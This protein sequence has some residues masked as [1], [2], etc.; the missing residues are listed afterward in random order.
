MPYVY[1]LCVCLMCMPYV[2]ACPITICTKPNS[3]K[4]TRLSYTTLHICIHIIHACTKPDLDEQARVCPHISGT[5]VGLGHQLSP[6][7][8]REACAHIEEHG[9]CRRWQGAC[10]SS[11]RH[12]HPRSSRRATAS[13][14][15]SLALL[16]P[17]TSPPPAAGAGSSA[18]ARLCPAPPE[19]PGSAPRFGHTKRSQRVKT[20]T[21]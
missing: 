6:H 7:I 18:Q 3:R 5:V 12:P 15:H 16:P 21:L 14:P 20:P 19:T 13:H 1:A 10:V 2:Y 4:P 8:P 9:R 17:W 11:P